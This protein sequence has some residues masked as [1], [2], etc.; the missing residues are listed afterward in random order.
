MLYPNFM[1]RNLMSYNKYDRLETALAEVLA[2]EHTPTEVESVFKHFR[3][4]DSIPIREITRAGNGFP[5]SLFLET[6]P[7]GKEHRQKGETYR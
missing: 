5:N 6:N 2:E 1:N 7:A 3:R 4:D